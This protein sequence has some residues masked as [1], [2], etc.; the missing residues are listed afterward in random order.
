MQPAANQREMQGLMQPVM[1]MEGMQ[2]LAMMTAI[3]V[4]GSPQVYECQAK[5]AQGVRRALPLQYLDMCPVPRTV[6]QFR[7]SLG[8]DL[9]HEQLGKDKGNALPI[10]TVYP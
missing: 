2:R 9:S 4:L 3:M 6:G 10:G 1:Q 8:I 7:R 5:E